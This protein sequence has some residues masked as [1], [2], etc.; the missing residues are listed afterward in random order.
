M[1]ILFRSFLICTLV[2]LLASPIF[3]AGSNSVFLLDGW[4]EVTR[5]ISTKSSFDCYGYGVS[6]VCGTTGA[7]S[8]KG[9]ENG[10]LQTMVTL[11]FRNAGTADRTGIIATESLSI[12]PEGAKLW[13]SQEP[14]TFDGRGAAWSVGD[15]KAGQSKS[16]SYSFAATFSEGA[17]GRIP[18][19]KISTAPLSVSISAPSSVK[20]GEIVA[21]SLRTQTGQPVSDATILV[22]G[23]D[24]SSYSIKTNIQGKASFVASRS[25]FHTYSV[26]NCRLLSMVSTNALEKELPAPIVGAASAADS[27]I[28]PAIIG[29]L[30]IIAGLFVVAVILLI[31]YN[32]IAAS[33]SREQDDSPLQPNPRQ[34]E[35]LQPASPSQASPMSYT[36]K[37]SFAES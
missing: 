4:L 17:E 6:G 24:G 18:Q 12:V 26:S 35:P 1:N 33:R 15:L 16:V 27:G 34:P 21:V 14:D 5:A 11:T 10:Q 2:L 8:E 20:V 3:A 29:V 36:Q 13:F 19:T 32:F 31:A 37:F 25:G 7:I 9:G 23:P 22:S 30:P 28:V